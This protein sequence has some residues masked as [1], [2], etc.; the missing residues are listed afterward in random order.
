[1]YWLSGCACGHA[2]KLLITVFSACAATL[3]EWAALLR[4]AVHVKPHVGQEGNP[5]VCTVSCGESKQ[6][7]R[8]LYMRL[9]LLE[10]IPFMSAQTQSCRKALSSQVDDLALYRL[11]GQE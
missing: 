6:A 11:W 8:Q 10:Q 5:Y 7:W 9:G 4:D 3:A 2:I 1:V